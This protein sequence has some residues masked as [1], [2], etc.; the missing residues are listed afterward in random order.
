MVPG[1]I[2][3]NAQGYLATASGIVMAS[4]GIA[5]GWVFASVGQ[6]IYFGMTAMA[7]AGTIVIIGARHAIRK[8]MSDVG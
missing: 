6:G 2:M 5:C 3:A 7:L 1:R 8:A 4:T